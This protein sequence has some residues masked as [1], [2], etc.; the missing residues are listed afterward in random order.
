[1]Q[2]HN[3]LSKTMH[4]RIHQYK[5]IS[6][7]IS[8]M[9]WAAKSKLHSNNGHLLNSAVEYKCSLR[10]VM[11]FARH[12]SVSIVWL[13]FMCICVRTVY[14]HSLTRLYVEPR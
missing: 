6:K 5:T 2:Q 13:S 12:I 4:K 8:L 14:H 9:Q 10:L 3:L 11:D 7:Q 1:M